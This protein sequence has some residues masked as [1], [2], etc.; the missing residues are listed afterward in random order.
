MNSMGQ[1]LAVAVGAVQL[2]LLVVAWQVADRVGAVRRDE[3]GDAG[4]KGVII[5]IATVIGIGALI[6]VGVLIANQINSRAPG[7]APEGGGD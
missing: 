4:G 5:L 3:R 1:R 2:A 7:L 6:G